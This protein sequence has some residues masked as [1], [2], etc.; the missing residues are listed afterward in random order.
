M[1]AQYELKFVD[2]K[3]ELPEVSYPRPVYLYPASAPHSYSFCLGEDLATGEIPESLRRS[4]PKQKSWMAYL[5]P[6]RANA[7]L[8]T[9]AKSDVPGI[10]AGYLKAPEAKALA[11]F[12]K[13]S[14]APYE[15]TWLRE[16]LQVLIMP[17]LAEGNPV[18]V[19]TQ[20]L[21]WFQRKALSDFSTEAGVLQ[22]LL[23]E[24]KAGDGHEHIIGYH[25]VCRDGPLP[26]L[27]MDYAAHG[28]MNHFLQNQE[29]SPEK[30]YR[31]LIQLV[32]GLRYLHR[33]GYAHLDLKCANILV[34][35][36]ER[37]NAG[38][39]V[40]LSDFGLS[41]IVPGQ[42]MRGKCGTSGYRS[43][44][45]ES[46]EAY[47]PFLSDIYS[48]G[49]VIE[50][51]LTDNMCLESQGGSLCANALPS[52][53]TM[54]KQCLAKD[55]AE[56]PRL[57]GLLAQLHLLLRLEEIQDRIQAQWS[58]EEDIEKSTEQTQLNNLSSG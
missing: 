43:P 1:R 53:L 4:I 20:Y 36:L 24:G 54:R 33:Q 9:L 25:G 16:F 2:E 15:R 52:L 31:L 19:I 57:D 14:Y 40:R 34:G 12:A 27:V 51:L 50:E 58:T 32:L 5:L 56:R 55:P 46:G 47:D 7:S 48:L 37:I 45:M 29:A 49:R 8:R 21:A 10:I 42:M 41:R 11:D 18:G 26:Y 28:Q 3:E 22:K 39:P 30:C 23:A 17:M 6:K 13:S 35:K 38:E 44:E